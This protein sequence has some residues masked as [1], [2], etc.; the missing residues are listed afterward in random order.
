LIST[1]GRQF[2]DWSADYR[3]FS[4]ARFEPDG[5]FDVIRKA[6]Y[7]QLEH[8]Q[9]YLVAMDDTI[10]RKR[11]RKIPGT[12]W[13]RDPMS[14]PFQ[15]N[16]VWGRR[17]IQISALVPSAASAAPGRAVPIDFAHAP[18]PPRPPR[19]AS[20][21]DR[22]RYRQQ[23]RASSVS[24][25]GVERLHHLRSRMDQEGGGDRALWVM[26]DGSYTNRTV[27]T[28]MP[29][30]TVLIGRIRRDAQLH[31]IPEP[32]SAAARGRIRR[33]GVDVMTP[34]AIRVDPGIP[35]QSAPVYAAGKV[36]EMRYKT[37]APV[38]WRPAGADRPLRVVVVA[39][40]AY[41][42]SKESRVL[43]RQP[44][45]LISTDPGLSPEQ[46]LAA[47]VNRWDIEVNIRD[48]KQ[49][50]GFDEAQVRT[51][52]SSSRAPQLAV[53]AYALLLTA[54]I[55][56]FGVNGNPAALPPAK[57]RAARQ[58]PRASTNDLINHV[59]FELWG[60]AIASSHFSGF[61]SKPS[62]NQKPQNHRPHLSSSLFY[63]C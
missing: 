26:V 7:D 17:F 27:L 60:R 24:Q 36:H 19:C 51:A 31:P 13:R 1:S 53:A 57:W 44:A 59:R 10:S 35:W 8:R 50:L 6:T 42:P 47:Y 43:Y 16:L 40:L 48:E 38:L 3:L 4:Q 52:S 39:P 33:Y 2:E 15:T 62:P 54:A 9:P 18:T 21:A 49:L 29:S 12:S 14:P 61:V 56:V 55:R 28:Q 63:A 20:E 30:N 32:R 41:R 37:V 45:F 34:D 5:V 11:G 25:R 58:K 22:L 46:I 23:V